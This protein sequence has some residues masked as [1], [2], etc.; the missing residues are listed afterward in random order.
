MKIIIVSGGFDPIHSGHIA[1]FN[2]AKRLGDRLIV[3][4][5]SDDWLV[6]K[7][8]KFFMPFEE[9]KAI[10][11]N[12]LVVD[13]V[14]DFD[15]D[16]I[17][18]AT[19]ALKKVKEL[20][21]NDD[22][23]FANGGD[24]NEGNIPEMSVKGVEF[25]FSVG[26]DDKKNSSSW[27]LKKWQYYHEERL[28]GSFYNLFEEEQ[29]K[30]KELIVHPGKGMSF[31]KHFKRHEIWMVSKGSC[32]VNYSK[33]DPDEKHSIQLNKFDH[34]LV[35]LGEWHQITNPF[36]D[37]CHLIEIQY[38]DECVEDDIERTEYYSA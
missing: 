17:G 18:S 23:A 24:R 3:A 35:P 34:Y 29:V 32:V 21:P 9:R 16:D 10:I 6:S 20:F 31:Q 30:V 5:N 12:L 13:S 38:G 37:T 14:I 1:Y 26:G 33:D 11:E 28:W 25:L 19:N 36:K 4:L 22:I 8:G 15:D 7:K 27:I 2:A